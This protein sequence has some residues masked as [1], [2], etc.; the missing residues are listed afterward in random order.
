MTASKIVYFDEAVAFGGALVVIASLCESLDRQRFDPVIVAAAPP[1]ALLRKFRADDIKLAARPKFS[2]VEKAKWMK[3][4]SGSTKLVRSVAVYLFSAA[5]AVI[6][7]PHYLRVLRFLTTERPALIHVN[8]S[9]TPLMAARLLGIPVVWHLHGVPPRMGFIDRWLMRRVDRYIAVSEYVA[10]C[11]RNLGYPAD[12]LVTVW[13]P[14]P[15]IFRPM[16]DRDEV[17]RAYGVNPSRV[18]FTHVGRIVR[19]KGQYELLQAFRHMARSHPHLSVLFV[20]S[21][22]EG[23]PSGYLKTLREYVV[24]NA[25]E[26]RVHFVGQIDDARELMAASDVVVHTS[27]EPEPF[28][29]VITEAMSVGTP[30]VASSLGAA[31]ELISHRVTGLLVDPRDINALVQTLVELVADS[32]IRAMLSRNATEWLSRQ[33]TGDRY[34]QVIENIYTEVIAGGK[35][36]RV[37]YG[38]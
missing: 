21:D 6:N 19:W 3:R 11:A 18:V 4:F 32:A 10:D 22:Q 37:I 16:R 7:L 15:S 23:Y 12:R 34:A 25:L 13:N 28:G 36:T 26:P 8:N 1:V 30:V 31:P 38:H 14:A 2:Y 9:T 33:H 20:G 35:R 27:V 17:L 5:A 24:A 29:L